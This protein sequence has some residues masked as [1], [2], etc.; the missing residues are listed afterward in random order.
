MEIIDDG[1]VLAVRRFG[2]R[3]AIVTLFTQRHGLLSGLV[4]QATSKA[5]RGVLLTGNRVNAR[6][7]ARLNEQLG[8][9]TL[10]LQQPVAAHLMNDAL[11]FAGLNSAC[12]LLA[13][14]LQEREPNHALYVAFHNLVNDWLMN[15]EACWHA[16]VE[17]EMNILASC[18][19]GLDIG[20][21][22]LT[23][24]REGLSYVSPRSGRAVCADA[25]IPYI[26]KLL[27]LP[28]FLTV[29]TSQNA[30]KTALCHAQ[31]IDGLHLAGYFLAGWL[32]EA[33]G[34]PLPPARARLV[35]LLTE[36]APKITHHQHPHDGQEVR[37]AIDAVPA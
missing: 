9:L 23:G 4:K 2:E 21:C 27:R 34:R 3:A 35:S 11:S 16:Y 30:Q 13:S 32:A 25:A 37:M 29:K 31:V 20:E 6:W 19:F 36:R 15:D 14:Y 18:G 17:L 33:S 1:M 7:H 8:T 22:A 5:M 10:E 12:A 26:P 28:G 24:V